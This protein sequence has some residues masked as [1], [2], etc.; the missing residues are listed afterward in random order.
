VLPRFFCWSPTAAPYADTPPRYAPFGD[1]AQPYERFFRTPIPYRGYGAALPEPARVTSVKIGFVGPIEPTVSVATGGPSHEEALGVSMM[2]GAQLAIDEANA[3]GGYRRWG[4]PFELVVRNDN[5]LW[6]AIGSEI[7]HL[8]YRDQV[9]AIIGSIDGANSHIAIRVALKIEIPILN[10][11][12]T[13][14]TYIETNI[15]WAFRNITD[16][17]QMCYALADA[18]FGALKLERI[19]ALRANNRYGRFGIRELRDAATRVGHPFL[20][21]QSYRVGETDFRSYLERIRTLEPDA[22]V[23]WGDARESALILQQMRALGMQQWFVGSDRIVAPEV[24]AVAGAGKVI[25]G[26]PFDPGRQDEAW[27]GFVRRF[28]ARFGEKPGT[29]AAYAY[30][31]VAMLIEA[32][33]KAGLNRAKIRTELASRTS[34]DGVTGEQRFDPTYGNIAPAYVAVL[35]NGRWRYPSRVQVQSGALTTPP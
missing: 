28:A 25:A 29:Y 10:T 8:A 18:L 35:E 23:T 13:D 32:I 30:D 24:A 1:F 27:H 5:G 11:A 14:P 2:H 31:G 12:D 26:H 19:A 9:W 16:D 34:F 6:G 4:T 33:E 21:E 7:I 15:P 20:V 22:V 17:R 3:R